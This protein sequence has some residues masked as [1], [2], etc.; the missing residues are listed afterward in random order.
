VV[1]GGPTGLTAA[2]LLGKFGLQVILIEKNQATSN[3]AKAI[4][5]DDE[6]LRALQLAGLD[7]DVYPIIVPGTGTR[8]FSASGR[9]LLH[10]RGPRGWR[11]GHPFKNPFAQPDLE[12]VLAAGLNRFT[13]VTAHFGTM[14]KSFRQEPDGV[15]AVVTQAD[16]GELTVN[17]QYLLGCDGGRSLVRER[18]GIPMTGQTFAERWLVVDTVGDPHDQRY[19]MHFGDPR[20]PHVIIPGAGGRCRYEFRLF[21]EEAAPGAAPPFELVEKLVGRYRPLQP[22]QVERAV[23]YSFHALL[24][25]RFQAGRCLLLGDA[26]H[27]MPPFAGQGLNSGIRDAMNLA[28]KVAAVIS[29]AAT[30]ELLGTYEQER[31]P[32]ARAVIDLSVRL[33]SIVMTTSRSRARLRDLTLALAM[34]LPYTRRYLQEMRFRPSVTGTALIPPMSTDGLGLAGRPLPQPRVLAGADHVLTRIDDVIGES[35]AILGVHL[36]EAD[37]THLSHVDLRPLEGKCIDVRLDDRASRPAHGRLSVA[38]ADGTLEAALG[39]ARGRMLIVR[40]D[41]IVAAV[42]RP[43]A[44]EQVAA[45]LAWLRPGPDNG[46]AVTPSA[47]Q[48][49]S[50]SDGGQ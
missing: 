15:R 16:G 23:V 44:I 11:Y 43:A 17:V 38:D 25:D 48:S 9:L 28:W 26:A 37:W 14:L 40:P 42:V 32:H 20:R 19:G 12:K 35:P 10:A 22:G 34:A 3:E 2:N 27:M 21:G 30:P 31:R 24:A 8:Y 41:R 39:A 7:N 36:E 50:G 29:G 46:H 47:V 1:G 45:A 13:G 33:G 5:L 6:S 18:L 49:I 4:S